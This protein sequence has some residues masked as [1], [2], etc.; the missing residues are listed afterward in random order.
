[1][2]GAC[3]VALTALLGWALYGE[4]L[5]LTTTFGIV[6]IMAG[7]LLIELDERPRGSTES[8]R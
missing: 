7:V 6:L 4:A 8:A 3:G 1:V 5:T 2:W